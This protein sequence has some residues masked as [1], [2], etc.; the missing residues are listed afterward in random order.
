MRHYRVLAKT[1]ALLAALA[2]TFMVTAVLSCSAENNSSKHMGMAITIAPQFEFACGIAG[3]TIDITVMVPPGA[4]PHT[5]EPTPSQMK[6]L[7]QAKLYAKVGSGIEFELSWMN[8]LASI[9][10]AMM[11]TDCSEGIELMEMSAGHEHEDQ[12]LEHSHSID[13]HIWMSPRNAAIMVQNMAAGLVRVDPDNEGLYRKNADDYLAQL[14]QL[15]N[16]I[17]QGLAG[18]RNRAFMVYHPAFGYFARDYGLTM[19]AIEEEGKEPTPA[20]MAHVITQARENNI[21]VIFASPQFNPQSAEVIA[22]A[23]DGRVVFIDPLAQNYIEN[24]RTL[25]DNLIEAME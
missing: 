3:D 8:K 7:S 20:G 1:T 2:L 11:I 21:N 17:T 14:E 13:P 25:S 6:A 5:Y 10:S 24:L 22:D 16:G 23:I 15:D 4:S 9:N 19:L 12:E 18:V